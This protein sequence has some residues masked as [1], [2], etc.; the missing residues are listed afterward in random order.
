MGKSS[1]G[2]DTIYGVLKQKL[3]VSTYVMYTTRPIR[4][5]EIDGVTY[6]FIDCDEMREY[7]EGGKSESVIEY[8]T[9]QTVYGPWTYATINDGQ[10][11]SGKDML[12]LGTLESYKKVREYFDGNQNVDLLPIYVEVPDNIRLKRAIEREEKE[13]SP[14]YVELCRRFIADSRDFS[15]E[16]LQ[17]VG[18]GKR[19]Q[20]LDLYKC[21]NEIVDYIERENERFSEEE[22]D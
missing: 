18:I 16:N 17:K 6:N 9:Y 2:K 15:E 12:M 19:F 11:G 7:V 20:N 4:D 22:R 1:S 13:C 8:R 21:V 10:F 3:D 5:G 14:K